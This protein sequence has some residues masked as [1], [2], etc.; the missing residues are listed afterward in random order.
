MFNYIFNSHTDSF[1][2]IKFNIKTSQENIHNYFTKGLDKNEYVFQRNIFGTCDLEINIDSVVSLF[3]KEV[4]DPFYIFQV[5]SIMLWLNNDY[6][7]YAIV[8]ILT[9]LISLIIS[10]YETRSNLVNIQQMAKYS[11]PINV[12]RQKEVIYF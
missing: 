10:V 3:L 11:S 12:F 1:S 8:I 5:F 6:A 2:S 4:T 9:T 7:K